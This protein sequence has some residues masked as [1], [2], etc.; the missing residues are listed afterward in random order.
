[1]PEGT[2]AFSFLGTHM[3]DY[4]SVKE[5]VELTGIGR[6]TIHMLVKKGEFAMP[7]RLSPRRIAFRRSEIESWIESRRQG[8]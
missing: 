4:L 2:R 6:T 1:M 7:F 3:R 5:V 8:V